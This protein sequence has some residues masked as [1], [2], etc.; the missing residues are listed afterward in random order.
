ME[1]FDELVDAL[2]AAT[3]DGV[4]P[5][6]ISKGSSGSYFARAKVDGQ[7][8]TV[9]VF[10]PKDEEPGSAGG[11]PDSLIPNLSYISEAAACLLDERLHLYIVPQTG[12]ASL[13]IPSFSC[14]WIDR[15]AYRQGKALPR[16]IGSL[17]AFMHGYRDAS[18]YFRQHPLGDNYDSEA[19]RTGMITKRFWSAMGVVCG[20]A[21]DLDELE[22]EEWAEEQSKGYR[23]MEE[24]GQNGFAWTQENAASFQDELERLVVL[25]YLM[26]N[27]DRGL[28][29]FVRISTRAN[30]H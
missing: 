12:L 1:D 22:N 16:K 3:D 26:R 18:E 21:G 17:Q 5:K 30:V 9:G 27:T 23:E 14:D 7:I 20:R 11:E 10:K 2:K 15:S 25:D 19:H 28:D 13:S 4:Q 29:D 6:M 24:Q 8:K